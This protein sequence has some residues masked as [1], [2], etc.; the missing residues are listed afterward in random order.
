MLNFLKNYIS[1]LSFIIFLYIFYS[2]QKYYAGF[3]VGEYSFLF[4]DGFKVNIKEIFLIIIK[5]YFILLIPFYA[6]FDGESK[7]RIIL[8]FL[9]NKIIKRNKKNITQAE[10]TAILAWIVKGF[11]A[12][13]MIFWLTGHIFELTN[14]LY[15]SYI[16]FDLINQS[17]LSY[18]NQYFFYTAFSLILFLDV[19]FFTLGYLIEGKIFKNE[20][21][22]VEPTFFGWFVALASYPPLNQTTN[23]ILG[24]YSTDFPQ[25]SN[26]YIHII[27]NI[28][29]LILMGI[30]SWASFSLGL[31]ASNL[32]NRG[33]VKTGP[34]K[35]IR[36][37]AYLCKNLSWWIGGL[38]IIIFSIS[39]GDFKTFFYA[40]IGLSFWSLIYYFRAKTEENHLSLDDD[41]IKY[42]KE[43]KGM[44]FPK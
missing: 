2:T 36:H 24:W 42:K 6:F 17:F 41:Y 35:Y 21:I 16:N 14:N 43:V 34:Y 25:F 40:I 8:G 44:F 32:T 19:L 11:F 5:L 37:P 20:I 31:K 1:T 4:L 9:Y 3:F 26:F 28:L 29:I 39:S 22:S 38:P 10:K 33:I 15:K 30:Y 23:T 18:F 7:A 27:L 13:L 12:P